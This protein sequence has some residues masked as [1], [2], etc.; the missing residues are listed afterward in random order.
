M[1]ITSLLPRFVRRL[2]IAALALG[3]AA[4]AGCGFHLRGPQALAFSTAHVAVSQYAELGMA[5]RREIELSGTTRIMED[6]NA[7][8][9]RLQILAN[10]R[11]RE[12]LSL[13]SAGKVREYELEQH[14]RFR[15][16]DRENKELIPATNLAVRREYTFSDEQ[17]L[18]KE[19]E[20]ALLYHDMEADLVRQIMWRLGTWKGE[21]PVD[22]PT[23]EEPVLEPAA[24]ITDNGKV[25]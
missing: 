21:V 10:E 1:T 16:V 9:V 19:Q 3:L 6:P 15:L 5:L 24:A 11:T 4:L 7:A 23:P 18:G 14:V 8:E 13:T 20:E 2:P 17:I 22:A 12:I 25:P